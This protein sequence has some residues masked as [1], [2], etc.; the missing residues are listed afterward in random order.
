[1]KRQRKRDT[2]RKVILGGALIELTERDQSARSMM[3]RLIGGLSR[4]QDRK[5]FDPSEALASNDE[6][7]NH[8]ERTKTSSNGQP[9]ESKEDARH[10]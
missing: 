2:R 9:H 4:E 10:G 5:M 8:N 7:E 3:R 1:M 6:S